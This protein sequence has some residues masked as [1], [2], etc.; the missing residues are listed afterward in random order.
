MSILANTT[1][2]VPVLNGAR[3]V[4]ACVDSLLALR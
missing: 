4:A 2:I 3:T 1:V